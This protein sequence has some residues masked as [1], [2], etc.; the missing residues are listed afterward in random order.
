MINIA[1]KVI[2]SSSRDEIV[3]WLGD[4]DQKVLKIKVRAVPEKGKANK[5]VET[6]LAK[7][8]CLNKKEVSVIDG[9]TSQRKIIAVNISQLSFDTFIN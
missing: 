4:G 1:V 8:L 7:K 6:L 9:L 5:A 2:P 3:G